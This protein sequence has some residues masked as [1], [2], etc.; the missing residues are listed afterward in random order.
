MWDMLTDDRSRLAVVVAERYA[1][2]QATKDQLHAARRL[3]KMV[4]PLGDAAQAAIRIAGTEAMWVVREVANDGACIA[5][6]REHA[7]GEAAVKA[8][9]ADMIRSMIPL[10][11]VAPLFEQRF[12]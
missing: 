1:N 4:I 11:E 2:G 6:D 8:E 7:K 9:Q 10:E 5:Y 12:S 3:A